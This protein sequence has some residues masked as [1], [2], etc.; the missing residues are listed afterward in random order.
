MRIRLGL[1]MGLGWFAAGTSAG[2]VPNELAAARFS[3]L[4]I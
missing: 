4:K 1:S 3:S 2:G